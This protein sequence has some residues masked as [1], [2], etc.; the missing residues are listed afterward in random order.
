MTISTSWCDKLPSRIKRLSTPRE[1]RSIPLDATG[2]RAADH[3]GAPKAARCESQLLDG[4][5]ARKSRGAA[6]IYLGAAKEALRAG[7]SK[8]GSGKD[9]MPP[10]R[11]T[12]LLDDGSPGSDAW[13]PKTPWHEL[14]TVI[15]REGPVEAPV[16]SLRDPRTPWTMRFGTPSTWRTVATTSR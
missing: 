14:R 2:R 12:T 10:H 6:T 15:G 11:R 9:S 8:M 13:I 7:R 16:A 5:R 1:A 4:R 3:L